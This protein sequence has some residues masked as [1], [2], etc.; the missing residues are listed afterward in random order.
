[1]FRESVNDSDPRISKL[2]DSSK[3]IISSDDFIKNTLFCRIKVE[4]S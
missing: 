1:M 3:Y 4:I 2:F